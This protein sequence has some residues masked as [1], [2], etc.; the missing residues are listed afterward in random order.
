VKLLEKLPKI[1]SICFFIFVLDV[2]GRSDLVQP[3]QDVG[4]RSKRRLPTLSNVG[5]SMRSNNSLQ[6]PMIMTGPPGRWLRASNPSRM[7]ASTV[8]TEALWG[9]CTLKISHRTSLFK[10]A[11]PRIGRPCERCAFLTHVSPSPLGP[12]KTAVSQRRRTAAS[13]HEH[14]A[15]PVVH[16]KVASCT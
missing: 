14:S 12:W 1:I 3:V 15:R 2:A 11:T 9:K 8:A 13:P 6:S 4:C 7:Y 5:D 16:L 10:S